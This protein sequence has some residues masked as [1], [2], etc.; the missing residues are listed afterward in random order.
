MTMNGPVCVGNINPGKITSGLWESFTKL[1]VH[2]QDHQRYLGG[3]A[4]L[5]SSGLVSIYRNR[6]ALAFM[7]DEKCEWLWFIDSDI[8]LHED[9][10]DRLM[11]VADAETHPIVGALYFMGND[12][13][14]V[15][16][17][18]KRKKHPDGT[19]KIAPVFTADDYPPDAVLEVDGLG[20]GCT[21]IHRSVLDEMKSVYGMP[22]PFFAQEYDGTILCGEDVSFCLRASKL[23]YKSFIA[24]GIEVGHEKSIVL[25]SE[26]LR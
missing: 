8:H 22:E 23:G 11:E 2:D 17:I 13:G 1:L 18:M 10:L 4:V 24:T 25:T 9:T 6:V 7:D 19:V 26:L 15:P 14:V 12:E 21:L 5:K 3:F 16:C 20:M